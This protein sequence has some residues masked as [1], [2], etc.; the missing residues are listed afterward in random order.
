MSPV[1]GG[2]TAVFLR[3]LASVVPIFARRRCPSIAAPCGSVRCLW[4][5]WQ[6]LEQAVEPAPEEVL[7]RI[8]LDPSQFHAVLHQDE[9]RRIADRACK[10]ISASAGSRR[11]SGN[12]A[13]CLA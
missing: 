6:A 7:A 8:P 12:K 4:S 5:L 1:D 11:S 3:W 2:A 9:G 10:L 13:A